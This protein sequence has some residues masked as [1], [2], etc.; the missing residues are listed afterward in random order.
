MGAPAHCPRLSSRTACGPRPLPPADPTRSADGFTGTLPP[1]G[2]PPRP[3]HGN[4]KRLPPR[5]RSPTPRERSGR[6]SPTP[7][8]RPGGLMTGTRRTDR[9][10]EPPERALRP[11]HDDQ[12]PA[13]PRRPAPRSGLS[14]ER[15]SCASHKPGE[16]GGLTFSRGSPPPVQPAQQADGLPGG[17]PRPEHGDQ[18]PS[19]RLT[20]SPG[21]APTRAGTRSKA[22]PAASTEPHAGRAVRWR[23]AIPAPLALPPT[24]PTRR[25]DGLP[26]KHGGQE[27]SDR[28][29]DNSAS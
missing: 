9:L 28:P 15:G 11:E 13:P 19:G 1:A 29:P 4:H 25:A 20:G 22:G 18:E 26:G 5:R 2:T 16:L 24:R 23:L 17:Q 10:G 12:V 27:P 14:V 21:G 3:E 7:P 6:G 8:S